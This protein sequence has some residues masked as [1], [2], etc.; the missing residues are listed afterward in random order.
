MG[1]E[2]CQHMRRWKHKP[3][4]PAATHWRVGGANRKQELK[5][6]SQRIQYTRTV[7]F[8]FLPRRKWA[9]RATW[10]PSKYPAYFSCLS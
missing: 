8:F 9:S 7:V 1:Y 4:P 3:L 6:L 10:R 2:G 5:S